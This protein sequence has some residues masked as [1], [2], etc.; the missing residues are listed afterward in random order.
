MTV[1]ALVGVALVGPATVLRAQRDAGTKPP[2]DSASLEQYKTQRAQALK[3]ISEDQKK[4]D[5]LRRQRAQLES[6]I[7]KEAADAAEA[8]AKALLLSDETTAL[9][10]LDSLL[11]VAQHNLTA[12]R[13]RFLALSDAVRRHAAGE[14]VVLVRGDTVG[15][16][17]HLDSL[18]VSVDSALGDT[19]RYSPRANVALAEGAVDEVYR[20]HVL[21]ATHA[22]VVVGSLGGRPDPVTQAASVSVVAGGTTYVQFTLRNGQWTESTWT[23]GGSP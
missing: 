14:L 1:A 3:A 8:R 6:R 7:A 17:P 22:V 20:S 5:E 11:S 19:R 18:H 2:T 21:P 10:G 12:Q 15:G 9:R 13:D 23:S 4:L 16:P